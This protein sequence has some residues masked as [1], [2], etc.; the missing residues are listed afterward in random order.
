[1]NTL[2]HDLR[3]G[4]RMLLKNRG[5]TAVA[6]LTLALGIGAN[7][8]IFSLFNA[9]FLQPPALVESPEQIV[10]VI[11]T[12]EGRLAERSFSYL[13]YLDYR[14]R[15][16]V[17]SEIAA[18]GMVWLYL[19]SGSDSTEVP[20]DVV[21][22][23]YFS[24]LGVR[25]ALG[26]F[27][28]PEEDSLASPNPV[29]VLSY[30]FWQRQF[31]GDPE[32]V[33]RS[34][35]MNGALFTVVGVA[36]EGF[37]GIHAGGPEL[38]WV[39]LQM[40]ALD[41]SRGE[42][43][44]RKNR[45]F[46]LVGRL[47]PEH[48][49][50]SAAD[51][52]TA[53]AAHLEAA[54]PETN[55]NV[56]VQLAQLKGLYPMARDSAAKQAEV[57]AAVVVCLLLIA[58]A[59]L[60]G[61][62]LARSTTR[63]KEIAIRLAL[64][65]G[66]ARLVRQLLTESLLLS[67]FGGLGG[68]LVAFW[69]RDLIAS[70]FTYSISDLDLRINPLVLGYTFTVSIITGVIFGLAP[71]LEATRFS[72]VAALK[73]SGTSTGYRQSRL[74]AILVVSQVALSL[75]LLVGAVLLIQS[76]RSVL[77]SPDYD[78]SRIAHFRLRPSRLGYKATQAQPYYRELIARLES[79][80]AVDSAVAAE[81]PPN[82]AWGNMV[83][84]YLPGEQ[85]VDA[86]DALR[87]DSNDT[88]SGF[89]ETVKMPLLRGRDFNEG[90]RRGSPLAVIVNETLAR[91]LWPER[92]PLGLPLVI[93]GKEHVVVGVAKDTHPRRSDAD[94]IPF[95][96]RSF[97][98]TDRVDLRLF[99][100]VS[101]EPGSMLAM[102]RREIAAV[103]PD[104]HIGQI[105]TLRERTALSYEP[106]RLISGVLTCSGLIALFLSVL[107]L[108]G[109]LAHSVSQRTR[110]IGIRMAM[111]AQSSD[112]LALVVGQGLKLAASGI[113]IGLAA[114]F[115]LTRVLSNYLYGI[116]PRDLLTFVAVSALLAGTA[117]AACYLPARR[118]TKVDPMVS[119]RCE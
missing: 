11:G 17:L 61:V 117:V 13:D 8:A 2:I 19:S 39:P 4:L 9:M 88:T 77:T 93:D 15:S 114:A 27:F 105:M 54:Y 103:N 34:V 29:A 115:A 1:M 73:D 46:D 18:Q 109:V 40:A 70:F 69:A 79:L 10:S 5:F 78:P 21:S 60:A 112:V 92:E 89:F 25:P 44:S 106:D 51:E 28:L 84:V 52:M 3:Y 63:R 31:G 91:R 23:N 59:N 116:S 113:A 71:A 107:G 65:A 67:L 56:S 68:L 80:P 38:I 53:L 99:V 37:R 86:G 30:E 26:R 24:L 58:C 16:S 33:G 118:A 36:P 43:I 98:Q 97:W 47:K 62:L 64:G 22:S 74:R 20:G 95:L 81:V 101:G 49:L 96:Y 7:S 35:R 66:R 87:V 55:K 50:E 82:S 111:G 6:V 102:L 104:V 41:K 108:Y 45:W 119:L 90:D 57:L 75:V 12:R 14:D 32:I 72:L 94:P 76:L 48:T 85:P 100:R 110:E 42:L 83:S